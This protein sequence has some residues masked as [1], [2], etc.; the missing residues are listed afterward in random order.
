[1]RFLVP[2]ELLDR[3][4][5]GPPGGWR[6]DG[7]GVFRWFP[8]PDDGIL[9]IEVW[10]EPAGEDPTLA[11][12]LAETSNGQLEAGWIVL[13]DLAGP[14]YHLDRDPYGTALAIGGPCRNQGEELRALTAGLAP[15]QVRPGLRLFGPLIQRVECLARGLGK[16]RLYVVPL[17]YHNAIKFEHYGFRYTDD[18]EGLHWIDRQFRPG[19]FLRRR[20]DGSRPFRQPWMADTIR[21]RSWAIRDGVLGRH[22]AAPRMA[23]DLPCQA[24]ENTF[25][26][27]HW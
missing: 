27:G 25:P 4:G 16:H 13:N 23:K 14:R 7:G 19:G 8:L 10:P 15:N 9:R 18:A 12:G 6:Q 5:L 20:M 11:L 17:A 24:P 2:P 26:G 22:W 1:M 3:Y 21:G